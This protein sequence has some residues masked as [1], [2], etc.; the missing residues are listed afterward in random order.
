MISS[1]FFSWDLLSRLYEDPAV[2]DAP[3]EKQLGK[4]TRRDI[5][6]VPEE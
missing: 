5:I 6:P 3:A 2:N 1:A 4:F